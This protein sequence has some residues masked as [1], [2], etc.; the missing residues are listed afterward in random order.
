MKYK[1]AE[2]IRKCHTIQR[3]T[4]LANQCAKRGKI[5]EIDIE[6]EPNVEKD[7]VNEENS[8]D[9]SSIFSESSKY[10]E[11]INITFDIM[12]SYS[13]LEHLRSRKLDLLKIQDEKLM[14][15]KKTEGK[16][17]KLEVPV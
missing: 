2:T 17:I 12:D 13:H 9:K 7:D 1:A 15:T 5:N 3:S 16:V 8:D 14:K 4:H 6:L 10:R 11:N